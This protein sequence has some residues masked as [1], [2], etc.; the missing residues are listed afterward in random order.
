[1]YDGGGGVQ[2]GSDD[3]PSHD[4]EFDDPLYA[5]AVA[6][7]IQAQIDALMSSHQPEPQFLSGLRRPY[8]MSYSTARNRLALFCAASSAL[9]VTALIANVSAYVGFLAPATIIGGLAMGGYLLA[10]VLNGSGW[11]IEEQYKGLAGPFREYSFQSSIKTSGQMF[12]LLA[13]FLSSLIVGYAELLLWLSR[14]YPKAFSSALDG[15]SALYFS[16]VTFATV[17]YGDFYPVNW[18]SR[19]VT[20]SEI[21]TSLF[22]LTVVLSTSLSWVQGQRQDALD[23]RQQR[24]SRSVQQRE[25]LLKQA[26]LGLYAGRGEFA[27]KVHEKIEEL[28]ANAEQQGDR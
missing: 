10:E 1:M 14:S 9:L 6:L 12:G 4:E 18:A 3:R 5:K 24:R 21:L 19:V 17:G 7:V 13:L 23:A 8:K 25:E 16:L 28:R 22:S 15:S 27:R 2:M 11:D 20:S 26:G